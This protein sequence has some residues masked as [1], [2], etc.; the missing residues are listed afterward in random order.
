MSGLTIALFG[1]TGWRHNLG[2]GALRAATLSGVL[3]REPAARVT[4]FDEG[5]GMRSGRAFV[6]GIPMQIS[7]AGA[8]ASRRYHRPESYL[9]MRVSAALGG[10]R[11][12]GL[13]AIDAA[14]LVLDASGGDSF[15]DLYGTRRFNAV[16]WPKRLAVLRHRPLV[17]LPQTYG[18]YRA[19]RVRATAAAL[20]RSATMAWARDPDSFLALADLLGADLDPSRHREGVDVAFALEP[21]EPD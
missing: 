15:T 17:L 2:V 21:R 8:R 20:T 16:T 4:A 9:N 5:W 6:A 19:D 1:V 13:A 7:L 10:L 14:D 11:N 12:A 3:S 18:P